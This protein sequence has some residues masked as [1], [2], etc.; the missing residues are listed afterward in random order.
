[1]PSEQ[2]EYCETPH[3]L[4]VDKG[5]RWLNIYIKMP[6]PSPF[7]LS[8]FA[9]FLLLRLKAGHRRFFQPARKNRDSIGGGYEKG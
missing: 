9:W 8:G 7:R 4:Q 3:E 6:L 1:M 2:S 5:I